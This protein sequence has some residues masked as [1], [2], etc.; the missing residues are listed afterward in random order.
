MKYR[1]AALAVATVILSLITVAEAQQAKK[2]PQIGLLRATT[3]P[4]AAPFNQAF[5]QGLRELGY[6]E[7]KNVLIEY[8]FAEGKPA[9]TPMKKKRI[10]ALFILRGPVTNTNQPQILK[11]GTP[12]N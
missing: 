10:G 1:I 3:P 7:G 4:L 11:L 2:I 6:E 12:H 5:Q 9:R 8:R